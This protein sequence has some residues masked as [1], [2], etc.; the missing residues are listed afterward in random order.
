MHGPSPRRH[1]VGCRPHVSPLPG[2]PLGSYHPLRLGVLEA[3]VR[4]LCAPITRDDTGL[5]EAVGRIPDDTGD[6][7]RPAGAAVVLSVGEPAPRKGLGI[8]NI[9]NVEYPGGMPWLS[10]SGG[11]P[12]PSGNRGGL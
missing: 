6:L 8:L 12:S 9:V 11:G 1:A 4:T 7:R 10:R 3:D 2:L 5:P